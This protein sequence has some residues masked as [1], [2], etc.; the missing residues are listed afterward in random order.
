MATSAPADAETFSAFAGNWSGSGTIEVSGAKERL[1]CRSTNTESGNSLK[2]SLRCASDSYK[3]ELT[4]DITNDGGNIS[5]S[6]N[7]TSRGV[8]GSLSGK[9]NGGRIQATAQ[10]VGF[11]AGLAISSAGGKQSVSIRSPGSEI[12]DVSISMARAR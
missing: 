6:W 9:I 11:T 1:R 5:G 12:S 10:S 8:S 3:F 4:S 2:L 7:E